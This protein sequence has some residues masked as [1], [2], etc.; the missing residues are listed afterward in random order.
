MENDKLI[1]AIILIVIVVAAFPVVYPMLVDNTAKHAATDAQ[2]LQR[3]QDAVRN[4]ATLKGQYPASL[5]DLSPEFMAQVPNTTA[6]KP[7]NYNPR[8]GQVSNPAPSEADG[9]SGQ[10]VRA[11][12]G[13]SGVPAS[14]DAFTGLGVSQ[15][16]NY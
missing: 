5:A 10:N 11:R 7:F 13:G 8:T 12:G 14:T 16:L 6:R 15:E 9:G 3:I 1:L 4:Y 2:N